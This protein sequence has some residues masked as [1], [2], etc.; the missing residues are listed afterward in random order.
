MGGGVGQRGF[1]REAGGGYVFA[2]PGWGGGNHFRNI[3]SGNLT[4]SFHV[5]EDLA[6]LSG[7]LG[8][9]VRSQG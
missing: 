5:G 9:L 4:Q 3:A 1:D 2:T 6:Q 7:E 8:G